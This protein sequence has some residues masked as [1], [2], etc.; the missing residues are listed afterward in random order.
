MA[1]RKD[2]ETIDWIAQQENHVSVE[3]LHK[4]YIYKDGCLISKKLKKVVG[5][6]D[7]S[8]KGYVR[9]DIRGKKY[10]AHRLIW[11]MHFGY[12]PEEMIIDHKNGNRSDN[13][14]ENLRLLDPQQNTENRQKCNKNNLVGFIGVSRQGNKF[15]ARI[16]IDGET[17]NIGSYASAVEAHRAYLEIKKASHKGFHH[18]EV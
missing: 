4:L 14:I 18:E 9:I 15:R 7:K 12:I 11:M 8:K 1:K 2:K 5:V 13:K 17:K 10:Y 3:E 6:C 16:R